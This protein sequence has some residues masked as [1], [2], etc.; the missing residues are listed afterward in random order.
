AFYHSHPNPEIDRETSAT[1]QEDDGAMHLSCYSRSCRV[2]RQRWA[3][4]V[5]QGRQQIV[6]VSIT[7]DSAETARVEIAWP[8]GRTDQFPAVASNQYWRITEGGSPKD[9]PR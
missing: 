8:S 2:S 7:P 6:V 4:T 5:K 9:I 3:F 1:Y